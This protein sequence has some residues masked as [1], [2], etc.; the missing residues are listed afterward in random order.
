MHD[1]SVHTTVYGLDNKMASSV[2]IGTKNYTL[3]QKKKGPK[4]SKPEVKSVDPTNWLLDFLVISCFS[5][6]MLKVILVVLSLLPYCFCA[7]V[8]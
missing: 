6:G 2:Y 7:G 4:V 5:M 8:R 3:P 1:Q